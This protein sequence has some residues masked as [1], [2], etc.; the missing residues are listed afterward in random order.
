MIDKSKK[1]CSQEHFVLIKYLEVLSS[2]TIE[3]EVYL[4]NHISLTISN[5]NQ[6]M[7]AIITPWS[8]KGIKCVRG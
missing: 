2:L 4:E 8:K 5:P 6:L 3:N 7:I 1:L